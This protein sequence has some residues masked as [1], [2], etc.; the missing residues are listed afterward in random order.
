MALPET[1]LKVRFT[2]DRYS[3]LSV[4]SLYGDWSAYKTLVMDWYNPNEGQLNMVCRIHDRLHYQGG[5]QGDDRFRENVYL[6]AGW[7][8]LRFLISDIVKAPKTRQMDIRRIDQLKCYTRS[9]PKPLDV[10]LSQVYL[11]D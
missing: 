2:Q 6:R 9:L 8:Q 5:Q 4:H 11:E 10:Y 7:N 3:T 1:L